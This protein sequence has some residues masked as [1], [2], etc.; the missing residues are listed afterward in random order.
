MTTHYV[1]TLLLQNIIAYIYIYK[2]IWETIF[3]FGSYNVTLDKKTS[4]TFC[5]LLF[6]FIKSVYIKLFFFDSD[7]TM[8]FDNQKPPSKEID[9]TP[10]L[11]QKIASVAVEDETT[12]IY[13]DFCYSKKEKDCWKLYQKMLNKGVTVSYD[14]IL[15]GMLTPTEL[16]AVQK[17]KVLDEE[18][19]MNEEAANNNS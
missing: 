8:A 16:R 15:R 5:F 14:T 17:Q 18:K 11:L 9:C 19:K 1:N 2:F 7:S 4:K 10:K 13:P 3:I 12:E 6:F